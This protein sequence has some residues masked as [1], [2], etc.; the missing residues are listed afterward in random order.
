M[1]EPQ[2]QL[3]R[4]VPA[5]AT[6]PAQLLAMAA[7]AWRDHGIALFR[8]E[9]LSNDFDRQAVVNAAVRMYGERADG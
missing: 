4:H 3:A 6:T 7:R 2:S 8:P 9:D 5:P 1:T